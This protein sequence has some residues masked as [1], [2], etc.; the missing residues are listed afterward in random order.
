VAFKVTANRV[1]GAALGR[2]A[3]V[4]MERS[5][6]CAG[7]IARKAMARTKMA[8][9][10]STPRLKRA[11][12]PRDSCERQG[13]MLPYRQFGKR[14]IGLGDGGRRGRRPRVKTPAP[15]N[16]YSRLSGR[17]AGECCW[18]VRL[19]S[20][21]GRKSDAIIRHS[22]R[23]R[24]LIGTQGTVGFADPFGRLVSHNCPL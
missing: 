6:A 8:K 4:V 18:M 15:H 11:S 7:A 3:G 1:P 12:Q 9:L 19:A 13:H 21:A 17:Y 22:R 5:W 23:N 10:L 16:R 24:I 2:V 20:I 14:T